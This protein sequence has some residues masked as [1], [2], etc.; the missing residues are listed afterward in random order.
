MVSFSI[1][2]T[3]E[4]ARAIQED[5]AKRARRVQPVDV[6]TIS[7]VAGTDASYRGD[8]ACAAVVVM[9]REGGWVREVAVASARVPCPY[10]PGYF[11]F[12][13]VPVL[14]EAFRLVFPPPGAT[15]V[16]G[17]GYA[18]PR[19]AGIATHLGTFLDLPTVG[20]AGNLLPGMDA[21]EP[22]RERGATSPVTMDGEV[23]GV[24]FRSQ[25]GKAPVC[26]SPGY[27]VTLAGALELVR[28]CT[29]RD[30]FPEPVHRADRS[31]SVSW[32]FIARKEKKK[33]PS[34]FQGDI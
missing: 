9:D 33:P 23:V 24:L 18:H 8:D 4:E 6:R 16:H 28:H 26:V 17:H 31:A 11:A 27:R 20:V 15:I 2:R 32:K 22:G 21:E 30:R 13:E 3:R 12:R 29:L 1:P 25:E 5:V 19:R 34:P 14:L 10:I 7:S